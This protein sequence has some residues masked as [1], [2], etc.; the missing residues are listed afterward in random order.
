MYT[1]VHLGRCARKH[2]YMGFGIYMH[3]Y[4]YKDVRVHT[5]THTHTHTRGLVDVASTPLPASS[6]HVT[7]GRAGG[8]WSCLLP[9]QKA[10]R[11]RDLE[12]NSANAHRGSF[13]AT[14]C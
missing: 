3:I 4:A 10:G 13:L 11:K 6:S 12:R 1:H 9:M 8:V 14:A 7:P 2:T 5:H